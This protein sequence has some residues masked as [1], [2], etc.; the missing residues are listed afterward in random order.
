MSVALTNVTLRACAAIIMPS[1]MLSGHMQ[2][3]HMLFLVCFS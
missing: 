3:E 1:H 2:R